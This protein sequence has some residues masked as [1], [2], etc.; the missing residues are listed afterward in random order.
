M[1]RICASPPGTN[2][3]AKRSPSRNVTYRVAA[4]ARPS[5]TSLRPTRTRRA[6]GLVASARLPSARPVS[7]IRC[8]NRDR[9]PRNVA[10]NAACAATS[11]TASAPGATSRPADAGTA[12]KVDCGADAAT[13]RSRTAERLRRDE[14][15]HQ[16]RPERE[17]EL[18]RLEVDHRDRPSL[19]GRT[20]LR[21]AD[22]L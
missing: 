13:T 4:D 9:G 17:V 8:Q 22:H 7:V 5:T 2:R 15:D 12:A 16:Q 10:A 21:G 11:P 19:P 14:A 3:R 6:G 1:S 20:E 18:G